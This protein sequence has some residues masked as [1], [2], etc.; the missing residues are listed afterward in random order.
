MAL[1]FVLAPDSF[2]G[3]ATASEIAEAMEIGIRR[4]FTEAEILQVPMADG[5]EGS[6]EAIVD[7]TDGE[8]IYQTVQGPLNDKVEARIGL[9]GDGETAV[10]EMAT[11][12][13]KRL[14]TSLKIKTATKSNEAVFI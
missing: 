7:S 10:I 6:T 13:L 2:K 11:A 8:F 9:H 14:V 4:I 3:S 1:K 5:G 12:W